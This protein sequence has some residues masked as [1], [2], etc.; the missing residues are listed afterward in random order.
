MIV[1]KVHIKAFKSIRELVLPLDRKVTVLIGPNE[2][3]KTNIL[4]AIESFNSDV[5]LL[6]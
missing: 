5:K 3:G 6:Y 2:S 4:K 1:S